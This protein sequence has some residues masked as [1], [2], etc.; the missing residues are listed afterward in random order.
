MKIAVIIEGSTKKRSADVEKAV[1]SLSGHEVYNLGMK[2]VDGEPD[3]T[4]METGFLTALLL[5]LGAVDFVV[6]GCGTGQGY[7]N[8]VLQFPGTACGL[9][10]DP[11]DAFLY[12]RVNAGNCVSLALNKGYGD[13][14]GDVNVRLLLEQLFHGEYGSGYPEA[15]REIQINARKKLAQVSVDAHKSMSEILE[16]MDRSIITN[17]LGFPGIVEFINTH[18]PDSALKE[19]VLAIVQP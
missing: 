5:N 18:A 6:G 11:A 12:S 3:L 16:G 1:K 15:R 8:M 4:Y 17:A 9:L 13:L 19:Q 7:M 10:I 14:A 2:Q